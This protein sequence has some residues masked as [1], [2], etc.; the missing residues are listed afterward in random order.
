MYHMEMHFK[1]YFCKILLLCAKYFYSIRI[2]VNEALFAMKVGSLRDF[3]FGL[4][5]SFLDILNILVGLQC[6]SSYLLMVSK[7][8]KLMVHDIPNSVTKT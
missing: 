1:G 3:H 6:R 7:H 5:K 8:I 4:M 2:W